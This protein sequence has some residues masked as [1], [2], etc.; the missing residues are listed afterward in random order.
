MLEHCW[1]V[2]LYSLLVLLHWANR[3]TIL[4]CIHACTLM[5]LLCHELSYITTFRSFF[6]RISCIVTESV[7]WVRY[8]SARLH[9][10]RL[11]HGRRSKL[12]TLLSHLA[13]GGRMSGFTAETGGLKTSSVASLTGRVILQAVDGIPMNQHPTPANS[14]IATP[15]TRRP[16]TEC[17]AIS[18]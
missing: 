16:A 1:S 7:A 15:V 18:R 13:A 10:V 14:S 8:R 6:L 5:Y 4:V 9:L 2:L 12:Q 11:M 17:L 3:A